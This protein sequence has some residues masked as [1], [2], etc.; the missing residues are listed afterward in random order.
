[1]NQQDLNNKKNQQNQKPNFG[2]TSGNK[3][4]GQN[5]KQENTAGSKNNMG[6]NQNSKNSFN[7]SSKRPHTSLEDMN[8]QPQSKK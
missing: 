7:D 3:N 6:Q 8:D 1:M 2:S 4:S 5:N